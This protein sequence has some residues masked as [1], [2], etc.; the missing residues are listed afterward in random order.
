MSAAGPGLV[1]NIDHVD[2][3]M[4]EVPVLSM[5]LP[6]PPWVLRL[7][8]SFMHWGQL[9]IPSGGPSSGLCPSL[10]LSVS[11]RLHPFDGLASTTMTLLLI[12][13][14]MSMILPPSLAFTCTD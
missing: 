13:K 9:L 3:V 6:H 4:G 2:F 11:P 12:P 8:Y 10:N 5:E 7:Q 1:L 14:V